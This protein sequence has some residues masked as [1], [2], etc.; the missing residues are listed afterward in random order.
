MN[1]T[2]AKPPYG[3]GDVV[4]VLLAVPLPEP[5]D[6]LVPDQMYLF[7]GDF[8]RV[9]LG[10]RQV[11][12]VVWKAGT[13]KID[14]NK[15]KPILEMFEAPSM[16]FEFRTFLEWVAKYTLSPLGSILKMA[17]SSPAALVKPKSRVI[18]SLS[19]LLPNVKI[20]SARQRVISFLEESDQLFTA[21]ELARKA[22]VS[23]SVV[24]GMIKLKW[25]LPSDVEKEIN[26]P[27]PVVINSGFTLS[28]KQSEAAVI[29]T[30]NVIKGGFVVSLLDGVP[31]SGKTE[32]YFE[33]I[34]EAIKQGRQVLVLLP[35]IALSAQWLERFKYRFGAPPAEWHSDLSSTKR[36]E[37]WRAVANGIVNVVVGAR[38]ALFLPFRDLSLIIVDEE[39]EG[40]FKQEEGVIYN[41]RDMAIVRAQ[42][43][44]IPAILVSATPS[45]ET[46]INVQN[47][48]YQSFNLPKRHGGAELPEI[49]I[50]DMRKESLVRAR[51]LSPKLVEEVKKTLSLGEQ[52]LLFLNRRGYAPLTLCKTCGHRFKCPHC[53]A[54]LV[55]HQQRSVRLLCHHCGFSC[56]MPDSCPVCNEKTIALCGPGVE[57]LAE[58]V[59]EI[60]PGTR[61]EIASSDSIV[62]PSAAARLINRIE[63]HEI[64]LIIGTQIVAKGYHFPM[65]TLV[66]VVDSDLGLSGGDLRATE[67]TYQLLYQVAGRAG[68]GSKSGQ[69]VLQTY[70][71]EHSIMRA[72]SS[73]DR[74]SFIDAEISARKNTDMPPFSR[75]AALIISGTNMDEVDEVSRSLSKKAPKY[76]NVLILG[77][78]PAPISIIRGR[79]RRRFLVR[80]PKTVDI[81]QVIVEWLDSISH[82]KKV[83]IQTDIDPYSFL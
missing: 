5:Y 79:H 56:A 8:V 43:A 44:D 65:L 23:V 70:M 78:A 11:N 25:L 15:I 71:P 32:V 52:V 14:K 33:A 1:D 63:N 45:L 61:I 66:G 31:G 35:E 50:I 39:H 26:L 57:R 82:T 74:D 20:T 27:K 46:I 72:L 83:R 49:S 13:K 64:D 18:Y 29:F 42:I 3:P 47:G 55:Y 76:E 75:L 69:V 10:R 30:K 51:W 4:A 81:Q 67:R 6:Y 60:F 28:E 24:K 38:S 48:R 80:A 58:E 54:W 16:C 41:A 21:T 2:P 22:E 77:P 19:S 37:I 36:R 53:T 7:D 73:G 9:S 34:A 17:I 62:S 59:K 68:R 12:G 40:A